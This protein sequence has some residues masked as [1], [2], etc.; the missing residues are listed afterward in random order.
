MSI[1]HDENAPRPVRKPRS[2]LVNVVID[3]IQGCLSR[4]ELS[5]DD[6]LPT[7][8]E[9]ADIL[10][11]SRT[12]IREAIKVL[13]IA[14]LLEIRKG[15]GTFVKA[16]P[17]TS[18]AQLLLFQMLL[19]KSTPQEMMEV[20]RL[21]ERN[22]A[23]LAA[24]RRTEADLAAMRKAIDDFV[25]VSGNPDSTASELAAADAAFHRV[26]YKA[27]QNELISTI[28][29][30]VL[31]MVMP[32]MEESLTFAGPAQTIELHEMLLSMIERK[33][34]GAAREISGVTVAADKNME[35]FK[36]SLEAFTRKK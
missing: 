1:S 3:Y 10:G 2:S 32:W 36:S 8:F 5:V 20:R 29:N 11:V 19:K 28:A 12:P 22:C 9:L 16:N 13:E 15:A 21:F 31:D 7:E 25:A 27:T 23:E 17:E 14:G 35:H 30:F 6:K 4:G 24:E 34:A 18:V 26:M 33:N